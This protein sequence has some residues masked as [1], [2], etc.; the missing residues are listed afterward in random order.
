M[1]RTHTVKGYKAVGWRR[2]GLGA[3]AGNRRGGSDD[4]TG[5]ACISLRPLGACFSGFSLGTLGSCRALRTCRT[6][7]AYWATGSG[8]SGNWP[9]TVAASSLLVGWICIN[10]DYFHP[11]FQ[12]CFSIFYSGISKMVLACLVFV[13][14]KL[15]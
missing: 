7:R 13:Y 2:K 9:A 3:M 5:R 1:K 15:F 12:I 14:L 8:W 11:S 10:H 4:R 6:L